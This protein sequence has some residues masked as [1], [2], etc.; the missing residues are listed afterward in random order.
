MK[1][2]EDI[3]RMYIREAAEDMLVMDKAKNVTRLAKDSMDNQIDSMILK[4]EKESIK[5][6][7]DDLVDLD[8]SLSESLK[9]K[10]LKSLLFEK[11]EDDEESD[12][13]E[14]ADDEGENVNEPAG[15]EDVE[16]DIPVDVM[17]KPKIDIDIFSKKI[18]RLALNAHKLLDAPTVVINR[19]MKFLLD[20]YDNEHA[21]RMVDILNNQF[22]F[23]LGKDRETHVRATAVG[24]FGG[25]ESG[26]SS[27]AAGE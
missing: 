1:T 4:F 25:G 3:L 12:E 9:T 11:D 10:T 16:V 13:E 22:D 7:D 26:T 8:K 6:E 2:K 20:N 18:A 17:L 27:P 5:E 19:A 15:S 14:D 24:A 23:N 21:D